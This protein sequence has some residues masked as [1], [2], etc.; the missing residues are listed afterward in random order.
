[1]QV[2]R[3]AAIVLLIGAAPAFSQQTRTVEIPSPVLVETMDKALGAPV[4]E[5]N[6]IRFVERIN[7]LRTHH[8]PVPIGAAIRPFAT[9]RTASELE[10]R[11]PQTAFGSGVDVTGR[12]PVNGAA[13]M[14]LVSPVAEPTTAIRGMEVLATFNWWAAMSIDAGK[15]FTPIDVD[16]LWGTREIGKRFCCDQLAF[17]DNAAD[18]MYWLLQGEHD[19]DGSRLKLLFAKGTDLR[20]PKWLQV[21]LS[22]KI[23]L[24]KSGY[25]LDYPDLAVS[26]KYIFISSNVYPTNSKSWAGAVVLRL[27]KA[28]VLAGNASVGRAFDADAPTLRFTQG[29]KDI[30]YFVAHRR[31]DSVAIWKWPDADA[32]PARPVDV[33]VDPWEKLSDA[34]TKGSEAPNGKPWLDRADGRMAS[35]WIARGVI[36]FAW[37]AGL[38]KLYPLPHVRVAK[39]KESDVAAGKTPLTPLAQ[40]HLWSSKLALAYAAAAPDNGGDVGLIVSY[41]GKSNYPGFAVAVLPDD[42][43]AVKLVSVREGRNTPQCPKDCGVWGDYFAVRGLASGGWA[44]TGYTI[45]T[46]A[47]NPYGVAL[48]YVTFKR[49]Q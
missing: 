35:A 34:T 18:A 49:H 13:G 41:G 47:S 30:M 15:T 5:A 12:F 42:N 22:S 32:S 24:G 8:N 20:K 7:R 3:I 37:N 1:M 40:P 10:M 43:A 14:P 26:D 27:D 33:D 19:K 25:W 39:V 4:L 21:E 2:E 16:E 9:A 11:R 31:Y 6:T 44:A 38:D 23:L 45:Q 48:E 28:R 29:A 46:S 36:G 17:Y